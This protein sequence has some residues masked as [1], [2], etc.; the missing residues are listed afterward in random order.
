MAI[1]MKTKKN[2][3]AAYREWKKISEEFGKNRYPD[4][5]FRSGL[6]SF[7]CQFSLKELLLGSY[8]AA[9]KCLEGCDI[10]KWIGYYNVI[11]SLNSHSMQNNKFFSDHAFYFGVFYSAMI[12]LSKQQKI[13]L[14][15]DG[16][17]PP[18]NYLGCFNAGKEITIEGIVGEMA[19]FFM[20]SG[21]IIIMGSEYYASLGDHFG[22]GLCG[23]EIEIKGIT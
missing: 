15:V 22:Y 5:I 6:N 16:T 14:N 19:G 23:G 21:K 11:S 10:D 2:V 9:K 12:S 17:T 20:E 8:N 3:S 7:P 13:L 4:K 18:L 1:T